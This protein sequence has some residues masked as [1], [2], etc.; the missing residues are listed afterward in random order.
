[1]S[2]A[3]TDDHRSLSTALRDWAQRIDGAE[4]IRAAEARGERADAW[5]DVVG[6][7]VASIAVP[8]ELG[9]GGGSV[10]DVAVAIEACAYGLVPGPVLGTGLAAPVLGSAWDSPRRK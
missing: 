4:R 6:H 10:L 8:A 2:I 5:P 9:G 7:G 1:M 3:I